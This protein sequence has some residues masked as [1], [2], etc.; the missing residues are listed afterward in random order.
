MTLL[1]QL[2]VNGLF[3]GAVYALLGLSFA[4]IF[5]TN[6]IWH[7]AQGAAYTASAY[8]VFAVADRL[9]ASLW[10]AIAAGCAAAALFGA[11]CLLFL[12]RPLAA[13]GATELVVVM[14]SLGFMIIVENVLV[15][16][17]GPTSYSL[18]LPL[19][20]PMI[21]AGVFLGGAQLVAIPVALAVAGLYVLFLRRTGQGRLIRALVSS[22]ELVV[23]NGHDAERLK[24]AA[25]AAGSVLLPLAA[26]LLLAGNAGIS[27]Y[28]GVPA[29]L[30]GAMAMFFGG[31]DRI[32]GA[33]PAGVAMG[34]ME[35]LAAFFLPTEWQTAVAYG[36][37]LLFLMWRP[38]GLMGRSLPQTS[39]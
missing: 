26:L 39:A 27:P 35:N 18:T 21:V 32:E 9:G 23:L 3:V 24:L 34:L 12:Y 28:M 22:P 1:A 16:V 38:T 7:F 10:L 2:L 14:A 6:R 20:E 31:V 15:L 8:V 13:R 19:P 25:F 5:A 29:V 11:G 4:T 37:I 36:A 33:A 17:F 30:T